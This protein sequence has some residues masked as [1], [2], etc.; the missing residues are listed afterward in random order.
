MHVIW[1]SF[2]E[3]PCYFLKENYPFMYLFLIQGKKKKRKRDK[4][5]GETNG[6]QHFK[7][8]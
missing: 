4:Q 5:P 6:K 3:H 8:I 2:A 1:A 7:I